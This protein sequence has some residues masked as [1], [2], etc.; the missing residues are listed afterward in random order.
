MKLSPCL[1]ITAG[2][3][4]LT[5]TCPAADEW[6]RFRGPNGTGVSDAKNLPA[7]FDGTNTTWKVDVGHG[8]S[9]PV[10]FKDKLF[11]TAETGPGKRAVLCLAAGTGKKLWSHE[12]GYTEHKQNGLNSFASSTPF[13]DAERVYVNWTSGNNVEA[14]ALDH[15][16]KL[17]WHNKHVA[18][19]VH[20]HGS[21]AS[22]IVADG[23]MLVRAEFETEKGGKALATSD[24]MGWKSSIVGLDAATGKQKW[25]VEVP[26]TYNPYSTPVL[27]ETGG[28]KH[29]FILANTTSGYMGL[30]AATGKI[31]WQHN[32]GYKQCSVGGF[33]LKDDILFSTLGSGGGGSESA[34]IKLG[35]SK[36]EEIGSITKGLPYV[37]TPLLVGDRLYMVNDGGIISC[38]KFPS[39]ELVYNER[40]PAEAAA[41]GGDS[42]G[43]GGPKRRGGGGARYFS[44]PV[45]ADGKIYCASQSGDVVVLKQG[46]EFEVLG[47]NK[48]DSLINATPAIAFNH[49]FIRTDKSLYCIGAKAQLP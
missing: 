36:P 12:L 5:L 49:L 48:M 46:D 43:G 42:A 27:R 47:V 26:N 39:G 25:K 15:N 4:A 13:V 32:P 3:A 9:S 40:L 28:G 18:D 17:V 7:K 45:A 24:Q 6:S 37:P 20:E 35:G 1:H 2:L 41:G 33:I 44:S 21:A 29:E 16:G 38:L 31:N 14:L 8:Y 34:L 10:L 30:D 22:A 11:V 19:Y 23:V